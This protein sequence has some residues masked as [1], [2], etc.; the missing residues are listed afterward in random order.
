MKLNE[1]YLNTVA[2]LEAQMEDAPHVGSAWRGTGAGL[3][4]A[5]YE[6]ADTVVR[7]ETITKPLLPRNKSSATH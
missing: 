5:K 3:R 6:K 7:Q 1:P 4:V 2:P